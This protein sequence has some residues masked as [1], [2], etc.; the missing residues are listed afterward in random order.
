MEQARRFR[1]GVAAGG[2]PASG[3]AW[4]ELA[5]KAEDLGYSTLLV[6]DHMSRQASPLVAAMAALSATTRLRVGTQ[7]LA[8]PLRNPVVLAKEIASVDLLSDGRFEPGLG[9]GWPVTSPIG[10]SD[11][12]QTGIDMGRA[13]ERLDRLVEAVQIIT[14]FLSSDEPFDF[15]GAHVVLRGVIPAPRPVQ[16]P[17]P[18]LMLAGAGPR[19]LRLA[20]R[21][22]DIINIAPRPPIVGPTAAGSMGYGMTMADVVGLLKEAAGERYRSIELCVFS[23]NP[24]VGNPSVTDRPDPSIDQLALALR[25][26]REATLAMPATLIGSE[27]SLV[28]RIESDRDRYDIS[29]RTIPA[30]SMDQFAPVVGR[31][32]GR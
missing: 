5:R 19:L 23:N 30:S 25:T 15:E 10:R 28:E 2:E 29:Y 3:R 8:N 18:P 16:R 4:A 31:L 13:G 11:S 17:H 20:A 21:H 6:A 1:F 12:E 32:A 27:S 9:A 24:Q 26:T 7:V 22:A 14:R